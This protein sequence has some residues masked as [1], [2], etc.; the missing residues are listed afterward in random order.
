VTGDAS[1][2]NVKFGPPKDENSASTARC[3]SHCAIF[4]TSSSPK[5]TILGTEACTPAPPKFSRKGELQ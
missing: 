2:F 1:S 4:A 3:W 5:F